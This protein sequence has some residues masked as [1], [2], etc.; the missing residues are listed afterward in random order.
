MGINLKLNIKD[1]DIETLKKLF[2]V[3]IQNRNYI[4]KDCSK[5]LSQFKDTKDPNCKIDFS[6]DF[7]SF[8]DEQVQEYSN[9][10]VEEA[11]KE[12]RNNG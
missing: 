6:F 1:I 10:F 2:R 11:R 5:Y 4:A 9:I 12:R 3:C 7:D 8:T